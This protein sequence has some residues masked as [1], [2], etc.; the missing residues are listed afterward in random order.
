MFAAAACLGAHGRCV[1]LTLARLGDRSD[2]L[3]VSSSER[4]EEIVAAW[5]PLGV[6]RAG[7]TRGRD[8][9]AGISVRSLLVLAVLASAGTL[10][11]CGGS[12]LISGP[13]AARRPPSI[14]VGGSHV[15][16]DLN[17]RFWCWAPGA[18]QRGEVWPRVPTPIEVAWDA[19]PVSAGSVTCGIVAGRV[20]CLGAEGQLCRVDTHVAG[21]AAVQ[22]DTQDVVGVTP[23][24]RLGCVVLSDGHV[25]CTGTPYSYTPA[26]QADAERLLVEAYR[27][28]AEDRSG[29]RH[30]CAPATTVQ[31][32]DSVVQIAGYLGHC[33]VSDAPGRHG[34]VYCWGSNAWGNTTDGERVG[35]VIDTGIRDASRVEIGGAGACAST[36]DGVW[37]WGAA[38]SLPTDDDLRA[39]AEA[40]R[41]IRPVDDWRIAVMVHPAACRHAVPRR[42]EGLPALT[43][44]SVG[45]SYA[46][47]TDSGRDLWCWGVSG[48]SSGHAYGPMVVAHDIV[49]VDMNEDYCCV[50]DGEGAV[51]CWGRVSPSRLPPGRVIAI[52]D[53]DDTVYAC[54]A[55]DAEDCSIE[56]SP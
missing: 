24:T 44:L 16:V 15:C 45:S 21:V 14:T 30:D 11:A 43:A 29:E 51:S 36:P 27:P 20:E 34:A 42:I 5:P 39:C 47:G 38:V 17:G 49:A 8:R 37:C 7:A 33:A 48:G 28:R 9:R 23:N 40:R 10:A 53:P 12:L 35:D 41:D 55:N 31:G 46:C 1:T 3:R 4:I 32:L 54:D 25:R 18:A 52:V 56:R 13:V 50:I 26:T 2:P 22:W 19:Q 6:S